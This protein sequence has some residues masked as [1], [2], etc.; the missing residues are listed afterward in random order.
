M[1]LL[2]FARLRQA[3][4]IGEED[5][6]LPPEVKTVAD[7]IQWLKTRDEV[8]ELAFHDLRTIRSAVNQAHVAFDTPIAEAKEIAFFPPVTGG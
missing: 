6:E 2:Y 8:F 1:K 4:G 7:V 5:V 3:V